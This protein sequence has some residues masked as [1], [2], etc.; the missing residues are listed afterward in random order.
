MVDTPSSISFK[1]LTSFK[2]NAVA[3]METIKREGEKYIRKY[4]NK[5]VGIYVYALPHEKGVSWEY[6][7]TSK[8][9]VLD[10]TITFNLKNAWIEGSNDDTMRVI[11]NPGCT[12]VI[13]ISKGYGNSTG[14]GTVKNLEFNVRP[15]L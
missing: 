3:V 2:K 14:A 10:E 5:D 15:R 12:K 8:D 6:E 1:Y 9:Y 11:L 7:N 4:K 13:N